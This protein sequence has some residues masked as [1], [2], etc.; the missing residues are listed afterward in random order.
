MKRKENEL[1]NQTSMMM[2][3]VDLQWCCTCIY[4]SIDMSKPK[5]AEF[6]LECHQH[7]DL[8]ERSQRIVGKG[9]VRHL[10]THT[11]FIFVMDSLFVMSISGCWPS[12]WTHGHGFVGLF[13]QT[14]VFEKQEIQFPT[15]IMLNNYVGHLSS[16][17]DSWSPEK[18]GY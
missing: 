4:L 16:P 17:L 5:M 6:K 2:F 14:K 18:L 12:S 1:R 3:H 15:V 8:N 10:I 9:R 13:C 7:Y 11:T